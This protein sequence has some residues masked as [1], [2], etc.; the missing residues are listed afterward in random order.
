MCF[1]MS[2]KEMEEAIQA[3][4]EMEKARNIKFTKKEFDAMLLTLANPAF[5]IDAGVI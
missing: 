4:K 2:D 5:A 3:V 1:Y